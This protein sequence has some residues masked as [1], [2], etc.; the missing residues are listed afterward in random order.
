MVPGVQGVV[1]PLEESM[2]GGGWKA[3]HVMVLAIAWGMVVFILGFL[4][5]VKWTGG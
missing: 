4:I 2:K 1:G 5:G 3:W